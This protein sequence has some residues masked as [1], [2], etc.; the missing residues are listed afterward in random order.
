MMITKKAM[1]HLILCLGNYETGDLA[2]ER[3]QL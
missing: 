3:T 1:A 2:K